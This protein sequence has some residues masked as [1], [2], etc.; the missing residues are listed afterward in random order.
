MQP[1]TVV[2]LA[3]VGIS[4]VLAGAPARA[5]DRIRIAL[6]PM[7]VHS[8]ENPDYL[9]NGL[10]DMMA[11]RFERIRDFDVVRID[12]IQSATTSLPK[13][14][15][16]ARKAKAEFVLFGSFTRFGTGASLDI[17]C[18][19][20]L[21]ESGKEP[22]REIFVQSGSIGDVIPDLSDL[23]G[24]VARF[25][26]QDFTDRLAEAGRTPDLPSS[27]VVA[28][29]ERRVEALEAALRDLSSQIASGSVEATEVPA[30]VAG[31]PD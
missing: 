24:K 14:L 13:A 23:V 4:V 12:E 17:Q 30:N 5:Q 28:N 7:V 20:V 27:R 16:A 15:K 11:S 3:V 1:K 21:A 29:L 8:A 18:A 25:V 9:R 26:I 2:F 19:G 22:L 31:G 6:L 10:A